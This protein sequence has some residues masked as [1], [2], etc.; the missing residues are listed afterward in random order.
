MLPFV[1][2]G[3]V[4]ILE[5]IDTSLGAFAHRWNN[6]TVTSALSYLYKLSDFLI[7]DRPLDLKDGEDAFIEAFAP[8]IAT[9]T[10]SRR[11]AIIQLR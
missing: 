5:D 2:P 11:T 10:L 1:K 3:G 6:G 9:I 7:G 8:N 4:Y